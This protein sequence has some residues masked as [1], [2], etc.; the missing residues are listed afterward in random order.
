[1]NLEDVWRTLLPTMRWFAGKGRAIDTIAITPG[2]WATPPQ[3]WPAVR[4]ETLTVTYLDGDA[5]QYLALSAYRPATAS[6][7]GTLVE[8]DEFGSVYLSDATA[9]PQAFARFAEQLH[10]DQVGVVIAEP[11]PLG[12][13]QS[14]TSVRIGPNA[15][16]K[17]YRRPV[18]LPA[19]EEELLARLADSPVTPTLFQARHSAAGRLTFIV[20][21]YVAADGDGW[22]QAVIACRTGEDFTVSA[23]ELGRTLRRLHHDLRHPAW[24]YPPSMQAHGYS[25]GSQ[26]AAAMSHRLDQ[27]VSEL[28][29]LAPLAEGLHA[30]FAQIADLQVP[31]QQIHGD[32]HLG[33]CL[34]RADGSGWVIIDFEGEPMAT[35][36]QRLLPDS[37]WRDVAGAL[38]SFA[39]AAATASA[40]DAAQTWVRQC[41][42]AFLDGYRDGEQIPLALLLAYQLDKAVYEA[43][44]ESQN[45]PDWA[46][47][48]L[49]FIRNELIRPAGPV[50]S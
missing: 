49:E 40:S 28:P 31:V 24:A 16:F 22:Q 19:R 5:E 44:Y 10:L 8:L 29:A 38:R 2:L 46:A 1:M 41:Q 47:I 35:P 37:P 27:A 45:R 6:A 18:Q 20:T 33:Q 34:H 50:E 23:A 21:D 11:Q 13:E 17:L 39:Y 7:A 9:D 25:D 4:E 43:R 3:S 36:T 30:S 12:V 42:T 14:N 32:F 15:L 26:I 48:P